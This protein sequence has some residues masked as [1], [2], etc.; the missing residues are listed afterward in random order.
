VDIRVMGD[1]TRLRGH[2]RAVRRH[3]RPRPQQ[4]RQPAAQRQPGVQLGAAQR[5]PVRIAFDE[6]PQDFR[7]IAGR[8]ATVSI[9]EGQR[10]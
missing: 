7:M 2:V 10:P 8:T 5:I 4:R 6:V 3:R 1:N 9:I